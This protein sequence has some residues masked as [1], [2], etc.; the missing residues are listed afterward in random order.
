MAPVAAKNLTKLALV[1]VSRK[2]IRLDRIEILNVI[3]LE[4]LNKSLP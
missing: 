2:K 3:K 4:I 1:Y